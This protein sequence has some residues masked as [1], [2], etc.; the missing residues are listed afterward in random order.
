MQPAGRCRHRNSSK[1]SPGTG[2]AAECRGTLPTF[3]KKISHRTNERCRGA[4]GDRTAAATAK[5]HRHPRTADVTRTYVRARAAKSASERDVVPAGGRCGDPARQTAYD[6]NVIV[7]AAPLPAPRENRPKRHAPRRTSVPNVPSTV[8]KLRARYSPGSPQDAAPLHEARHIVC[9][10]HT[11][12][13]AA[14]CNFRRATAAT[15]GTTGNAST[16]AKMTLR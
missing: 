2:Y 14:H 11:A 15:T 10:A 7:T 5:N 13:R 1:R 4:R 6:A 3:R 12:R 8:E 16:L 9:V